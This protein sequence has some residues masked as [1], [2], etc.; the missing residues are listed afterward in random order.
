MENVTEK[1]ERKTVNLALEAIETSATN[2]V[3]RRP[4]E[5]TDDAL[6][7]LAASIQQYGVIH[8]ILV[9]PHPEKA[10]LYQLI[11]GERRYRASL[12][13]G[14]TSI[15][16]QVAEVSDETAIGMQAIENIERV[17]I[18]ALNECKGYR[19]M[20]ENNSNLTTADLAQRFAKSE[21]YI[22]QRLKLNDLV[23]EFK[24]DFYEDRINLGHA[25]ILARLTPADQRETRERLMRR[26]E[27]LGTVKDL[28][29]FVDSNI[30]NSLSSAPFDKADATL[31]PKAGACLTCPKRSGASPLL[32]AEIKDK[33]TCADRGCF[34][35]KC[36]K[37]LA[38][39]TRDLI[40]TQPD[41]VFLTDYS[42]PED[43]IL[44][45]LAEHKLLPLR[46][47]SDFYK[48]DIGGAK[49]KGLWISGP[50][51]GHLDTV[52]LPKQSKATPKNE[53]EARKEQV[54]K[55]RFRMARGKEL[56]REKVYGRI[57]DTL[58]KHPSQK[59]GFDKKLLPDE[60]V[61]LWYIV[62]DKAGFNASGE[63]ARF[64]GVSDKRDPEK[65]YDALKNLKP[66]GKAF[67]LRKIMMDQYGGNYP[68]SPYGHIIYKVAKAYG[69]IDIAGFEK[70]QTEI[71]AKREERAK[72]RI[73]DLKS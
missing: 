3:F 70:E 12:L 4:S 56:D 30:M 14:K 43:E 16:A 32:F 64:L 9:R 55:I 50:R 44:D 39:K 5:V 1:T 11:C 15:P 60:E 62:F 18:H 24:K 6:R 66:E 26:S 71:C 61:L 53:K 21:T 67:L 34:F 28:Q 41:V 19:V 45:M 22:L 36:R 51:A 46:E 58:H 47:H 54:E 59:K 35:T 38:K 27:E 40:D 72:S 48:G 23:R 49:V 10:D 31:I 68:D 7:E 33:D 29:E 65:V 20:L 17:D 63:L 25:I 57:L 2:G 52:F 42:Q 69:D 37:F 8:A 13:A 73:R